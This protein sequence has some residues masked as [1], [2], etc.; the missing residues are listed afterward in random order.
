MVENGYY[1]LILND[2][3]N[4]IDGKG[5][6]INVVDKD[7]TNHNIQNIGKQ[8]KEKEDGINWLIIISIIFV[9]IVMIIVSVFILKRFSKDRYE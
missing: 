9:I 8:Q 3:N 4:L 1:T 6:D 7:S 5:Q 2:K